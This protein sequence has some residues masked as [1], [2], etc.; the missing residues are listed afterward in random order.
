MLKL[1]NYVK[2][3][4]YTKADVFGVPVKTLKLVK[5]DSKWNNIFELA[6]ECLSHFADGVAYMKNIS[7]TPDELGFKNLMEDDAFRKDVR[8]LN[9]DSVFRQALEP[10]FEAEES[11]TD[12]FLRFSK[13]A[14]HFDG[15]LCRDQV[16]TEGK[17]FFREGAFNSYPMLTLVDTLRY[18]SVKQKTVLFDYITLIDRS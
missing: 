7:K 6:H 10:I 5:D 16:F 14:L 9:T 1:I 18:S 17:K 15:N 4:S 11:H 3:T 2:G 8:G 13:L 12:D